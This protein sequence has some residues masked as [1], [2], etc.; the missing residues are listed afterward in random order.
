[1]PR[2]NAL[3]RKNLVAS[4]VTEHRRLAGL[5]QEELSARSGLST[6][7]I[8]DLERGRVDRPR[9]RTVEALASA[10][11]P[12]GAALLELLDLDDAGAYDSPPAP[13]A[14]RPHP[15]PRAVA[16]L[17]GRDTESDRIV[18]RISQCA[19]TTAVVALL[20][21]P[22]VGK[23]ALATHAGHRVADRF[24]N[25]TFFLDLR[26]T[27]PAPLSAAAAAEQ[28]MRAFGIRGDLP[29][30]EDR[31]TAYQ[32]MMQGRRV[33]LVLDDADDEAQV[34]PLLPNSPGSAML[35]TSRGALSGLESVARIV[36]DVLTPAQAAHLLGM[37]AG[38]DR[39]AAEPAAA[40]QIVEL[41]DRLPLAL[42]IAG[43]RLA[44]RPDWPLARMA[45]QLSDPARRLTALTA[46]DLDMRGAFMSSYDR[47]APATR[48]V[49][50]GLGLLPGPTASVEAVAAATE[51]T[52]QAAEDE[53]ESLVDAHILRNAA[54]GHYALTGL[55]HLLA[56][57]L[58]HT[59]DSLDPAAIPDPRHD[60][61]PAP[62]VPVFT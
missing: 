41:C 8:S 13:V 15:L 14:G 55:L 29:G 58:R 34:R 40:L 35:I 30:D 56:R 1:M 37:M 54:N 33:L 61:S 27:S 7:A 9:R 45:R 23:T 51:L 52:P 10:L 44:D 42:R 47:L 22:G 28:L 6:R 20:G 12:T 38:H 18:T 39:I 32:W 25:G 62:A 16:D 46:G 21:P 57:E 36:L 43:N 4:M 50:L 59:E 53:L 3:R 31:L 48:Q 5:T 2:Y 11:Q 60:D 26:G 17:T 19:C 49:F 24:P